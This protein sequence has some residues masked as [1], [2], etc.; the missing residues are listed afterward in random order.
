[1]PDTLPASPAPDVGVSSDF[2]TNVKVAQFG[3]GYTQRTTFGIN[4]TSQSLTLTY[5]N[6]KQSEYD[7]LFAF[8]MAHRNGQAIYYTPPNDVQRKWYLTSLKPTYV[9]YGVYSCQLALTEC[10]DL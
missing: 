2:Q 7:I 6:I 3:D 9:A 10:F 5:T 8:F 1:M 4:P